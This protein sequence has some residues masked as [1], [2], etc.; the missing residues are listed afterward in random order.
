MGNAVDTFFTVANL[1]ESLAG[2]FSEDETVDDRN[3]R[4]VGPL[5]PAKGGR[6]VYMV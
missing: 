4:G 6:G 5:P 1:G 2:P 3:E